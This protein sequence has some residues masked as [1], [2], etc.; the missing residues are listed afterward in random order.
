MSSEHGNDGVS[1]LDYFAV[2]IQLF[3]NLNLLRE[4]VIHNVERSKDKGFD[5]ARAKKILSSLSSRRSYLLKIASQALTSEDYA[6]FKDLLES[7]IP[8]GYVV[9]DKLKAKKIHRKF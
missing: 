4:E 7:S 6:E 2:Q 8:T 3:T 5:E 9:W 1:A